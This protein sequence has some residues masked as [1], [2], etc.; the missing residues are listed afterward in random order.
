MRFSRLDNE[1]QTVPDEIIELSEALTQVR[2][3][4]YR[5]ENVAYDKS[6]MY[7]ISARDSIYK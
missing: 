4:W 2:E 1:Q 5:T 7:S 3:Y 6:C